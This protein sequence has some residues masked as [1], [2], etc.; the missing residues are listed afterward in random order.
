MK[1]NNDFYIG[2]A[3]TLAGITAVI[4]ALIY[5]LPNSF[6]IFAYVCMSCNFLMARNEYI[7][8]NGNKQN[9]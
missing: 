9:G 4:I 2:A 1:T 5:W 6:L 8:L 3:G 7:K